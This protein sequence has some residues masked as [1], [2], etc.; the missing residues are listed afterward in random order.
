MAEPLTAPAR[1]AA[2]AAWPNLPSLFPWTATSPQAPTNANTIESK[3]ETCSGDQFV[4]AST[5]SLTGEVKTSGCIG[6]ATATSR[7]L[8]AIEAADTRMG[9]WTVNIP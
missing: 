6:V 4:E 8:T 5:T 7:P 3:Y 9:T 1:L 2:N